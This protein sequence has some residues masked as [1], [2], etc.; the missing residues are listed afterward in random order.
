[1]PDTLHRLLILYYY[2]LFDRK[3][4]CFF[5]GTTNVH[6][7]LLRPSLRGVR[8]LSWSAR[9]PDLSPIEHVWGMMKRNLLFF[10][11]LP[12]PLPNCDNGCKMLGTIYRRMT[13]G[14]FMTVCMREYT[15][16]LPPEEATLYI[17]VSVWAPLTV[18]RVFHLV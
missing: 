1:M 8:Q 6:I 18:T 4:M 11:S 17:D 2:H 12:Q 15:P 13:F 10:Q 5:S 9:T 16:A 3:V 14:T 7:R